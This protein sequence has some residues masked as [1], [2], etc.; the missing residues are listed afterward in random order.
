MESSPQWLVKVLRI[1]LK[2]MAALRGFWFA[3]HRKNE[4]ADG[5]F[6]KGGVLS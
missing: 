1:E 3:G 5:F 2:E 6:G 4:W